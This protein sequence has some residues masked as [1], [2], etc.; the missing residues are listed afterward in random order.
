MKSIITISLLFL[1]SFATYSQEFIATVQL[2]EKIEGVCDS[3]AVY[4]LFPMFSNQIEAKCPVSEPAI[5]NR[6][7]NHVQYL[8]DN[9]KTKAKGMVSVMINCN[10]EVVQCKIDN[11]T[12]ITELDAQI[13]AV[14]AD[15]GQ[16]TAGQYKGE[17]VDNMRL[18][19]FKIKKGFI[20]F[21]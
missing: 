15:L 16:W 5:V 1:I 13:V 7:N 11:S 21:E 14:F 9:P 3:S 6:L 18:Y 8:K 12:Q 2:K 19:S 20:F 4:A 17:N 10:G